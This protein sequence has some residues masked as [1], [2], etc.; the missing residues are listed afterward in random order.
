MPMQ[1]Q[2]T[3]GREE[4]GNHMFE[5]D[6]YEWVCSMPHTHINTPKQSIFIG[7]KTITLP[8]PPKPVIPID[9]PKGIIEPF[10]IDY[11]S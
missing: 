5:Y 7:M 10:R 2:L 11:S 3:H 6:F 8:L 1:V 9:T 4:S